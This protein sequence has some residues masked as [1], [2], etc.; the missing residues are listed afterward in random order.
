MSFQFCKKS[1]PGKPLPISD[2]HTHIP[3]GYDPT[4]Y[5]NKISRANLTSWDRIND[6]VIDSTNPSK[7]YLT[8]YFDNSFGTFGVYTTGIVSFNSSNNSFAAYSSCFFGSTSLS[9]EVYT[10]FQSSNGDHYVGGYYYSASPTVNLKFAR[11]TPSGTAF[12]HTVDLNGGVRC[13]R[14]QGGDIYFG[15]DFTQ[16]G[17]AYC[18]PILSMN[19]ANNSSINQVGALNTSG[20]KLMEYVNSSWYITSPNATG[21]IM[22]SNGGLWALVGTGFNSYVNDMI[23]VNGKL[24]VGGSMTRNMNS[25]MFRNYVNEFDGTDWVKVGT[26]NLASQCLDLEY[27]NGKLYAC[28]YNAIVYFGSASNSWK[29]ACGLEVPAFVN[30]SKIKFINGKLYGVESGSF[31]ELTK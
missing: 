3:P 4:L 6:I 15:G 8:G 31:F 5:R 20:A 25:S 12:T 24:Y 27:Y 1:E 18:T 28:M 22:S 7:A 26:N 13:V 30:L 14:E 11:K 2:K 19:T 16:L 17:F 23:Q 29:N 9:S 21:Y 10:L